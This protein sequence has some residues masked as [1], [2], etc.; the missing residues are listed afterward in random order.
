VTSTTTR[1]GLRPSWDEYGLT[2]ARAVATRADCVRSQVGAAIFARDRR[3]VAVGYNG[4]A[5]SRPGCLSSGACP[6][7]KDDS[8]EPYSSYDDCIAVHAEANALL[9]ADYT[10]IKGATIYVTRKPCF[11][12]RKLIQGAG[13]ARVVYPDEIGNPFV[14]LA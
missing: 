4:A 14:E 12:C 1:I 6:R 9:F 13:I 5:A 11:T 10:S 3:V 2:I 8:V 7:A